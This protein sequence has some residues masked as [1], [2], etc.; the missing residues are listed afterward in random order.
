MHAIQ[1]MVLGQLMNQW[2]KI[3]WSNP[4]PSI[5]VPNKYKPDEAIKALQENVQQ[6]LYCLGVGNEF[7]N[8]E[9]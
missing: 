6:H 7:L 2:H 5:E 9:I 4:I 3:N 8:L 1:K